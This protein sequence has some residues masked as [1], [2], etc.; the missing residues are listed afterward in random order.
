MSNIT[1]AKVI[2]YYETLYPNDQLSKQTRKNLLESRYKTD[3]LKT[4]RTHRWDKVIGGENFKQKLISIALTYGSKVGEYYFEFSIKPLPKINNIVNNKTNDICTALYIL[5]KT[6]EY[7]KTILHKPLS[8]NSTLQDITEYIKSYYYDDE[9]F[10]TFICDH[11]F[12]GIC[13]DLTDIENYDTY[14]AEDWNIPLKHLVNRHNRLL[15]LAKDNDYNCEKFKKYMNDPLSKEN[16]QYRSQLIN[17]YNSTLEFGCVIPCKYID[18][19]AE[20][21]PDAFCR[22]SFDYNDVTTT[23]FE[24]FVCESIPKKSRY[25]YHTH[26]IAERINGKYRRFA[27]DIDC[28]NFDFLNFRCDIAWLNQFIFSKEPFSIMKIKWAI[29]YNFDKIET[30]DNSLIKDINDVLIIFRDHI[31]NSQNHTFRHWYNNKLLPEKP[32]SIHVYFPG[33]YF[34]TSDLFEFSKFMKSSLKCVYFNNEKMERNT[35]VDTSVYRAG[36]QIFRIPFSGKMIENRQPIERVDT[37]RPEYTEEALIDFYKD[38]SVLPSVDD[39][40]DSFFETYGE[41]ANINKT[42]VSQLDSLPK[43]M[44]DNHRSNASHEHKFDDIDTEDDAVPHNGAKLLVDMMLDVIKE[45]E[46]AGINYIDHRSLRL[47]F[48][49][50]CYAIGLN[51][52]TIIKLNEQIGVHHSNGSH[53]KLKEDVAGNDVR[54]IYKQLGIED[55]KPMM[56]VWSD[57]LLETE[58]QQPIIFDFTNKVESVLTQNVIDLPLFKIIA[59]HLFLIYKRNY[60]IFKDNQQTDEFV[61]TEP[62]HINDVN[63]QITS[64]ELK[65]KH[66][67]K[68]YSSPL[69]SLLKLVKHSLFNASMKKLELSR[70]DDRNTT[71]VTYTLKNVGNKSKTFAD[72]PKA[73]D[74]ILH[75]MLDNTTSGLTMD[76]L[77]ER[78]NYFESFIAYKF[79]HPGAHIIHAII[80]GTEPGVG[81]SMYAR[82]LRE[83]NPHV[84][85]NDELDR[86][87]QQFNYG[88]GDNIITFFNEVADTNQHSKLKTFITEKYIPTEIKFGP[89]C[90]EL[91]NNLKIFYTNEKSFSFLSHNDRRFIVMLG[92]KTVNDVEKQYNVPGFVFENPNED[93][94]NSQLKKE[95]FDY[96]INL[97]LGNFNPNVRSKSHAITCNKIEMIEKH[98][99]GEDNLT[100]FV[101]T[102]LEHVPLAEIKTDIPNVKNKPCISSAHL[103]S[104]LDF[105]KNTVTVDTDQENKPLLKCFDDDQQEFITN[106]FKSLEEFIELKDM[107]YRDFNHDEKM[108]WSSTLIGR[109]MKN[110]NT[111]LEYKRLRDSQLIIPDGLG[112]HYSGQVIVYALNY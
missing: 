90:Y 94:I 72:R 83:I 67:N 56:F 8:S 63:K 29:D 80:V 11:L 62:I 55:G 23:S 25:D 36:Q 42:Y 95:Y 111:K 38:C 77:N 18:I 105:F 61:F 112:K 109:K 103:I 99:M 37:E 65:I 54:Y 96:L 110:N 28:K 20:H 75:S 48:V 71:Y 82:I 60:V 66:G 64:N 39:I 81:K 10:Y 30:I 47:H 59:R 5:I 87:L 93:V 84:K 34:K 27:L 33:V 52:A 46:K 13:C 101:N 12:N 3:A 1:I 31:H 70:D 107:Y 53:E 2:D 68:I 44:I 6:Y 49:R 102:L 40:Y 19:N 73:I 76:D 89:R 15:A 32:L 97:D 17:F 4:I 79:Q 106:N 57:T 58:H 21:K 50:N 78:V 104:L 9:Q 24:E 86:A 26:D 74:F 14:L 22:S 100:N 69:S 91:N 98:L 108:N 41:Y 7:D 85:D 92:T 16:E 43:T 35:F 51:T 88:S 45:K